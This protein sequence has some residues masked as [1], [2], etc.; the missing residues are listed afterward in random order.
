MKNKTLRETLIKLRKLEDKIEKRPCFTFEDYRIKRNMIHQVKF[1][2]SK[3]LIH[4]LLGDL[5]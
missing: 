4:E 3:W 5:E 2:R 1:K